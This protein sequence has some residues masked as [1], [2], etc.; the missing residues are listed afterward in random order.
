[1]DIDEFYGDF[2]FDILFSNFFKVILL[3][4]VYSLFYMLAFLVF[5]ESNKESRIV[6]FVTSVMV[7]TVTYYL[8]ILYLMIFNIEFEEIFGGIILI[9]FFIIIVAEGV[10]YNKVIKNKLYDGILISIGA[11][12]LTSLIFAFL[13]VICF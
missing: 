3:I 9:S 1:M 7:K 10:I 12:F 2:S 11:N 5:N 4:L 6:T 13:L 8:N